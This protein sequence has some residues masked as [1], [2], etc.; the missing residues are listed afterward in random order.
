M[1]F[2]MAPYQRS[3]ILLV[4]AIL[5]LLLWTPNV[6]AYPSI[7]L[8]RRGTSGV[9]QLLQRRLPLLHGKCMLIF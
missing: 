7:V 2:I 3:D 4:L 6:T 8:D 5:S 9:T 1:V